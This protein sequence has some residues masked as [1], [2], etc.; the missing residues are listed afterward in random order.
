DNKELKIIRKDVAECLRT[1]PKCGNQPDDPLA[2]VDVWHCAMAKR[3]VYDNPD[4][5]VIK[6]RSMKMCTKIIT[7]PA[8]VEN[9]KKVASRCVDRETQG[10]KSNRQKAVNIIGCALR[11]GVAETTVLARKKHHHHHH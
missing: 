10:P 5:A 11:A 4:P 7:D 9:C 2:R 3:G 1:L 6:E 8:N